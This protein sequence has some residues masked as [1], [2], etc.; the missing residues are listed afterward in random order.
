[1]ISCC[2]QERNGDDDDDDRT[3]AAEPPATDGG[4]RRV[5]FEWCS[6]LFFIDTLWMWRWK[7]LCVIIQITTIT[8]AA[9]ATTTAITALL[10]SCVGW[11]L[12][13]NGARRRRRRIN[14]ECIFNV[15]N[16][17][18]LNLMI[19]KHYCKYIRILQKKKR[20]CLWNEWHTTNEFHI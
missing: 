8:T 1:M 19:E 5:N 10:I 3:R 7:M 14:F 13:R 16:S 2:C 4:R 20:C 12:R 17:D 9:A 11:C 15:S 6:P 18:T